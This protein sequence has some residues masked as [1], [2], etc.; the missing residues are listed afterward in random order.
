MTTRRAVLLALPAAALAAR[1]GA[2][3]GLAYWDESRVVRL[4]GFVSEPLD[5]F[6]H[7]E[8]GMRDT[9]GVDWEVDVTNDFQLEIAGLAKDGSDF[10]IGRP[11]AVEAHPSGVEGEKLV[12]ALRIEFEGVVHDL[13]PQG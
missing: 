3:H 11:V 12:K 13:F 10:R 9:A 6:P 1:A 7:W 4:E 8:F 2:H 5:G